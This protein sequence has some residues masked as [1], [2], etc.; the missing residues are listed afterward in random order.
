VYPDGPSRAAWPGLVYVRLRPSW[1]RYAD[2]NADPPRIVEF[3]AGH[4]GV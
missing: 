3:A 4:L 1:I 2:Y